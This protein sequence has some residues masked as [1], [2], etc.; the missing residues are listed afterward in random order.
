VTS[1][2][3]PEPVCNFQGRPLSKDDVARYKKIVVVFSE[4]IRLMKEIDEPIEKHGGWAGALVINK[5]ED[6]K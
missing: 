3:V 2:T 6:A 4:T 5:A 1:D